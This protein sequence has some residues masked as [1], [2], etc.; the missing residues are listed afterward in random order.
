MEIRREQIKTDV[1]NNK[2]GEGKLLGIKMAPECIPARKKLDAN[3][4]VDQQLLKQFKEH[5]TKTLPFKNEK[6]IFDCCNEFSKDIVKN[7]ISYYESL[8]NIPTDEI[9][10]FYKNLDAN[11]KLG[12][13]SG[14]VGTTIILLLKG[15]EHYYKSIFKN[16]TFGIPVSRRVVT[17][18]NNDIISPLGWVKIYA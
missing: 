1:L 5:N 9:V 12:W 18:D 13:A 16:Y 7:E 4:K 6:D 11:L 2:K 3:I 10:E 8:K 17:R 14:L 15:E